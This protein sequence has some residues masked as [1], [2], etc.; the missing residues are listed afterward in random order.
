MIPKRLLRQLSV[1]ELQ[2]AIK[3]KRK[4]DKALRLE[5]FLEGHQRAIARITA[6]IARLDGSASKPRPKRK[7]RRMSAET[8]RK[9]AAAAKARAKA[10]SK[11]K[12]E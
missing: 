8:R 3:E 4:M 10:E 11:A 12:T 6:K 9:M 7:R 2:D 5:K 1:H